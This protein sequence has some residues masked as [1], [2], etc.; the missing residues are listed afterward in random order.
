MYKAIFS[1][2]WNKN[3]SLELNIRMLFKKNFTY[4][5]KPN[6]YILFTDNNK[7]ALEY[8]EMKYTI[9]R[10]A[11]L[12]NSPIHQTYEKLLDQ[13]LMLQKRDIKNKSF[14][15]ELYYKLQFVIE[16]IEETNPELK[17]QGHDMSS[18]F[19]QESLVDQHTIS[20]KG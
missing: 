4:H 17:K 14:D 13:Y 12:P 20:V 3:S 16:K 1:L 15:A 8:R 7:K 19:W 6:S 5:R 9:L 10:A 11:S 2:A 18:D